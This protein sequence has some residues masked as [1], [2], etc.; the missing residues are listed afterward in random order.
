MT[1]FEAAPYRPSKVSRKHAHPSLRLRVYL[2][3]TRLDRH[4][5]SGRPCDATAALALRTRQLTDLRTRRETA[6]QLRGV[7]D[8]VD[9]LGSQRI[10]SAVV[11][12]RAAVAD[13]RQPIL[14]LASRLEQLTPVSPRG[15]AL[16]RELLTDGLGPFYDRHCPRSVA[17]A[18]INVEDA[19]EAEEPTL[20]CDAAF[21]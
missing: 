1:A 20:G 6:R 5:A 10:V 4:I 3:R 11:I 14:R 15:V 17:E 16:A 18:V 8:Y 9:R 13:G 7:T 2:T 21:V 19:L 12:E